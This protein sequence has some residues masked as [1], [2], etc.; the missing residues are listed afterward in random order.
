M[1]N[2]LLNK[3]KPLFRIKTKAGLAFITFVLLSA[4]CC[5]KRTPPVPP[6]E[7]VAQR[8]AITGYQQGN[9]IILSWKMPARNSPENDATFINRID[10]YRLAEPDNSPEQITEAEFSSRSTLIDSIPVGADDF[11]LKTLT[12]NDTLKFSDQAARLRY[13]I[14][15]VNKSG[16]KASFSNFLTIEPSAKIAD[17]PE[18]LSSEITQEAIIIKW[19]KPLANVDGSTPANVLG[20]NIYRKAENET[21]LRKLNTTPI[22]DPSYSDSFF[23]FDKK[24]SYVVRAVSVGSEGSPVESSGSDELAVLPK[25]IFPPGSPES[26]T[27][28]ASPNTIS[29]FFAANP[30]NDISGYKIFRTTDEAKPMDDWESLTPDPI[31]TNTFQDRNITSGIRYYYF[32]KAIDKYGNESKPSKIVSETAP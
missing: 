29:L 22:S 10:V 3:L 21:G 31:T 2:L 18:N 27:I 28:A 25:D 1:F 5:G 14:R 8:A 15:Y 26:I 9:Q 6:T 4:L 13:A 12:Y 17:K 19:E 7:R 24:Y 30:E 16:Q 23:E 11:G 32:I 20:Y